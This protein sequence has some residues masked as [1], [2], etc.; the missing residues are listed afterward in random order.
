MRWRHL[1]AA[2]GLGVVLPV[3]VSA[4]E[5]PGSAVSVGLGV[6]GGGT[7]I[8][9]SGALLDADVRVFEAAGLRLSVTVAARWYSSA[10]TVHQG[11]D[12]FNSPADSSKVRDI[13]RIGP[14][15]EYAIPGTMGR[16]VRP[17]VGAGVYHARWTNLPLFDHARDA[18]QTSFV[19]IGITGRVLRRH[20]LDVSA[21]SY[22][23]VMNRDEQTVGQIQWRVFLL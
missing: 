16:F 7:R 12:F 9:G 6:S 18:L 1:L 14:R 13:L 3:F 4:Q 11:D 21:M 19:M 20:S 15:L 8:K 17:Y 23:N 5:R 2:S 22:R 10:L